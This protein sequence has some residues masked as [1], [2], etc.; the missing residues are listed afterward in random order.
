MSLPF[1]TADQLPAGAMSVRPQPTVVLAD[2]ERSQLNAVK[3]NLTNIR[4]ELLEL[5]SN[6]RKFE[7]GMPELQKQL[8]GAERRAVNDFTDATVQAFVIAREKAGLVK[9]FLLNIDQRRAALD[10]IASNYFSQL[11]PGYF[12]KCFPNRS[13][14]FMSGGN[15]PQ[16]IIGALAVI[17]EMLK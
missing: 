8:V 3:L 9:N 12:T 13:P 1:F 5:E 11:Y 10:N 17:N 2:H 4:A 14:D 16:R 6:R 15:V 7:Q